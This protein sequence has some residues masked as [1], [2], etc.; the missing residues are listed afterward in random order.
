VIALFSI[1][2]L[3][4]L[5]FGMFSSDSEEE[6]DPE[7]DEEVNPDLDVPKLE[8]GSLL[9]PDQE[10]SITTAENSAFHFDGDTAQPE[11]IRIEFSSGDTKVSWENNPDETFLEI[12]S[13]TGVAI[14]NYSNGELPDFTS[15][16]L[17]T[18]VEGNAVEMSLSDYGFSP[19][20]AS[21]ILIFGDN[22][23]SSI[24]L[25]VS[26]DPAGSRSSGNHFQTVLAGD[27]DDTVSIGSVMDSNLASELTVRADH[28]N[29]LITNSNARALLDGGNGFDTI[30]G[31]LDNDTILGGSGS[32]L[33]FGGDGNDILDGYGG[34]FQIVP[35]S[36]IR[37][38]DLFD[39]ESD[40]LFG[41]NGDDRIFSSN[42]DVVFG[43]NGSDSVYILYTANFE[44]ILIQDFE[45]SF[46]EIRIEMLERFDQTIDIGS[47]EFVHG[48]S[49]VDIVVDGELVCT[50]QGIF[51][52]GTMSV[53]VSKSY[54]DEDGRYM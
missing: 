22:N 7:W 52:P 44:P 16:F 26:T 41:G 53:F 21:N 39:S 18:I 30:F 35:S 5:A 4:A 34:Q 8:D 19:G 32:D 37:A 1:A 42:G 48:D 10:L 51:E 38:V 50:V 43:G 14:F 49:A 24:D 31:G 12:M 29:D 47:V 17:E 9:D 25:N 2:M 45:V 6:A 33:L 15:I 11:S 36:E 46:D 54:I 20:D 3:G 28:G 27:G 40:T 23:S 13:E